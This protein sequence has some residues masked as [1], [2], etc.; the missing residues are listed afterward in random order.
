[1]NEISLFSSTLNKTITYMKSQCE[2]IID[3]ELFIKIREI[4][5]YEYKQASKFYNSSIVKDFIELTINTVNK[6]VKELGNKLDD[7][8]ANQYQSLSKSINESYDNLNKDTIMKLIDN[9]SD[10]DLQRLNLKLIIK[11]L[12]LLQIIYSINNIIDTIIENNGTYN[13]LTEYKYADI[14]IDP[15]HITDN[16]DDINDILISEENIF[17][18][19]ERVSNNIY[20][21]FLEADDDEV[22]EFTEGDLFEDDY[23]IEEDNQSFSS[24][25]LNLYIHKLY[26]KCTYTLKDIFNKI[27]DHKDYFF[28]ININLLMY[29]LIIILM[30]YT[31]KF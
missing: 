19:N 14:S 5:P 2:G 7:S 23:D 1:M 20:K 11:G 25:T 13:H 21:L 12:I 18:N 3:K 4:F 15:E 22:I 29:L 8:L 26:F 16:I 10:V 28:I 27:I 24:E 31:L 6:N 30:H 17:Y 9:I